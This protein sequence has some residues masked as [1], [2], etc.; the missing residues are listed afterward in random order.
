[1]K[2]YKLTLTLNQIGGY[3]FKP[4]DRFVTISGD[5][6][7]I[8]RI[9]QINEFN[10]D[11]AFN[12]IYYVV[13]FDNGNRKTYQH[14]IN[15][16]STNGTYNYVINESSLIPTTQ[17]Y[18]PQFNLSVQNME[19]SPYDIN[20]CKF[21]IGEYVFI[22]YALLRLINPFRDELIINKIGKITKKHQLSPYTTPPYVCLYEIMFDDGK[23]SPEVNEQFISKINNNLIN[24]I[25]PP[26]IINP[27]PLFLPKSSVPYTLNFNSYI[28]ELMK[29]NNQF[30][31]K[32]NIM[33]PV[34]Y[35]LENN[36]AEKRE[37]EK[38]YYK[39]LLKLIDK[40]SNLKKHK[41]FLES[42][43]GKK[44]IKKVLKKYINEYDSNWKEM[45]DIDNYDHVIKYLKKYIIEKLN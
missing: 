20:K 42:N 31:N 17:P 34:S 10:L 32:F 1:M 21:F 44:F 22:K 18:I 3:K 30:N 11:L 29:L 27:D 25:S 4:G 24:Y 15:A 9:A 19:S 39:S 37:V 2:L 8:I 5:Y 45:K 14:A 38:Y 12:F 33:S 41:D 26:N 16:S 36:D 13:N 6:G 40:E 43:I 23:I 7:T 28:I 35:I